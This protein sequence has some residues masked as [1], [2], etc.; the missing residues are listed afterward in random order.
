MNNCVG[1]CHI[2][3]CKEKFD[4]RYSHRNA[5]QLGYSVCR[6]CEFYIKGMSFCPCCGGRLSVKPRNS[7][8]KRLLNE[9]LGVKRY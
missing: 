1:Y 5:F 3:E 2:D 4:V 6:Q 8:S 9:K 7:T